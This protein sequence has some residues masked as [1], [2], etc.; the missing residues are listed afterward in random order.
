MAKIPYHLFKWNGEAVVILDDYDKMKSV[1]NPNS[2]MSYVDKTA[3]EFFRSIVSNGYY[4]LN[5]EK[6]DCSKAL[7]IIT[8]NETKEEIFQN[9]GVGGSG[10]GAVRRLKIAEFKASDHEAAEKLVGEMM[11][12]VCFELMKESGSRKIKKVN[13]SEETRRKMVDFIVNNRLKQGSA[14]E[15]LEEG[16]MNTYDDIYAYKSIELS[17]E[18]NDNPDEVGDFTVHILEKGKKEVKTGKNSKIKTK[19]AKS[20][21]FEVCSDDGENSLELNLDDEEDF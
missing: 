9:F 18:P 16:I 19:K 10:G 7:F 8:S 4:M 1:E 20:S 2:G 14:I 11:S 21:D 3:D 17:Y 12:R 13:F 15:D 5:D 6:V